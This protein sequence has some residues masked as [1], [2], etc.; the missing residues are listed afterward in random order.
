[1]IP[2]FMVDLHKP[3]SVAKSSG[4]FGRFA[5]KQKKK[6]IVQSKSSCEFVDEPSLT[7]ARMWANNL[8]VTPS[9]I[10]MRDPITSGQVQ[11]KIEG[12]PPTIKAPCTS[13]R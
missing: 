9:T 8:I 10:Y 2:I 7:E 11:A 4:K 6:E 13:K 12:S 3:K 5:K 1:M